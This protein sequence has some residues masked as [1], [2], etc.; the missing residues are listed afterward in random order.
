LGSAFRC[1]VD[2]LQ[3]WKDRVMF[4]STCD[5]LVG[6]RSALG[7][8]E[9]RSALERMVRCFGFEFFAFGLRMPFPLTAPEFRIISNYPPAWQER[10]HARSYLRVDPTVLHGLRSLSPVLWSQLAEPDR[11]GFWGEAA[12]PGPRFERGP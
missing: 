7:L 5:A 3:S 6:V 4:A 12:D 2:Q 8:D 11:D 9:C 10:Y 1:A